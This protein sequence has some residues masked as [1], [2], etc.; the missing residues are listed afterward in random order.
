MEIFEQNVHEE[1]FFPSVIEP[2]FGIGR[3][4][5]CVMEHCFKIR[6]KDAKR[7]YFDFPPFVVFLHQ[8]KKII[9]KRRKKYIQVKINQNIKK[10]MI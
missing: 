2:S 5:Y 9:K 10:V 6:E 3:I 7:T 8:S 1:K 4:V